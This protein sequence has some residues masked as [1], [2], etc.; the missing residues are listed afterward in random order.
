M[1]AWAPVSGP[2]SA[3]CRSTTEPPM[4]KP[5]VTTRAWPNSRAHATAA[6][7][8]STSRSPTVERPPEAP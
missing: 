3:A 6:A 5:T 8:S 2:Y 1:S 7:R 4:E